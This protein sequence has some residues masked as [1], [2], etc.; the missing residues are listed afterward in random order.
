MSCI[1]EPTYVYVLGILLCIGAISSY[2]PQY[3]ALIKTKQAKGI[4]ELSLF[5]LNIGSFCLAVNSVILNWFKFDCYLSPNACPMWICGFN[6]LSTI[7]IV[8]GW[9][10]VCILHLIFVKYKIK[11]SEK[12]LIYGLSYILIIALFMLIVGVVSLT[13]KMQG[14]VYFFTISAW[15]LG[16]VVSPICSCLVWIPQII[17]LIRTQEAGNLSLWMFLL[18][19]P[20]NVVVIAFQILSHQGVSTWGTYVVCLVEQGIIVVI[21]IIYKIRDGAS[22]DLK[23]PSGIQIVTIDN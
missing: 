2:L 7:Q 13:E 16:G 6:L 1:V 9:L 22:A 18:Q 11:N 19:T 21:L 15:I 17:K 20:G 3:Y 8:I 4:S 5:I 10:M 14:A 23:S 12:G